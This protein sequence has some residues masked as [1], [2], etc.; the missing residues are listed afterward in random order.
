MCPILP[1]LLGDRLSFRR[2]PPLR[3]LAGSRCSLLLLRLR[4]RRCR[5]GDELR[6]RLLD[7]MYRNPD[8]R[9]GPNLLPLLLSRVLLCFRLGDSLRSRFLSPL[10]RRWRRGLRSLLRQFFFTTTRSQISFHFPSFKMKC[11]RNFNLLALLSL[12]S[13]RSLCSPA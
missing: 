5:R 2:L 13:L 1:Y 12:T 8:F 4:E 6:V 3:Y 11:I 10:L 7:S 9:T